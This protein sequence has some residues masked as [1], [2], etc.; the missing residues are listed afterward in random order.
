MV[1]QL[2]EGG[3]L[4]KDFNGNF[5]INYFFPKRVMLQIGKIRLNKIVKLLLKP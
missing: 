3:A 1:V 4:L 5:E 2:E